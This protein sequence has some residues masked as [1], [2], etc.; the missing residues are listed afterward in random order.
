MNEHIAALT[1][2]HVTAQYG[3]LVALQDID[4]TVP[5]GRITGIVGPNGAGKSTLIDIITGVRRPSSGHAMVQGLDVHGHGGRARAL[6]GVLP[7][8]SSLYLEL[9][10]AQ[11]LRF[12]AALYGVQSTEER[13]AYV[14]DVVNLGDR[15][16]ALTST[17]SG[18]MQRRVAI[19]RAMLHDPAL[20]ILD[21]PTLGVDV[22]ARNLIWAEI[23][24]LRGQGRTVI[25]TTNYLDEAEALCDDVAILRG[26]RLIAHDTPSA[27]VKKIGRCVMIDCM[28]G[29]RDPLMAYFDGNPSVTRLEP[30]PTGL[31][32][33]VNDVESVDKLIQD[34]LGIAKIDGFRS[35]APDLAELIRSLPNVAVNA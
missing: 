25:L 11:N 7:Q 4:L 17:L 1:V 23:R 29:A 30:S 16:D 2:S 27:L 8:A 3:K 14:L 20:L 21:E 24:A 5:H 6:I 34:A 22:D 19:A 35:R 12:A 26:G 31:T 10:V 28:P 18:G 33:Y 9:T 32:I 13:I 15:A